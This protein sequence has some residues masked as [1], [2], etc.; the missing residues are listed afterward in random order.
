M[1]TIMPEQAKKQAGV[2]GGVG[3]LVRLLAKGGIGGR[4]RR[5][6][7]TRWLRIHHTAFAAM[8]ADKEPSWDEVASAL[9]AMGVLDGQEKPP[10]GERVRKAWWALRRAKA[11][12]LHG[13]APAKLAVGEI[14]PSVLAVSGTGGSPGTDGARP[15]VRLDLRPA[16]P[17]TDLPSSQAGSLHLPGPSSAVSH[18]LPTSGLPRPD[19]AA[20]AVRFNPDEDADGQINRLRAQ[21]TAN[22]VPLPAIVSDVPSIGSS[23]QES[24]RTR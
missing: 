7:L 21:M 5:S 10:N 4:G 19:P 13:P 22:R 17:L 2:T 9:A 1:G 20:G 15:R 24:S 3:Q 11:A 18:D 23:P 8:L 12:K 14:A 6:S 16:L